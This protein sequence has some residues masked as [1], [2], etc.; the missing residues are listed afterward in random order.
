MLIKKPEV[1]HGNNK[2][3]PY[4]E[5][6]YHKMSLENGKSLVLIPGMYRSAQINYET[7]FLMIY[8]GISN[9][10]K[11]TDVAIAAIKSPQHIV[12]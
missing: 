7:A 11:V 5:G 1:F 8:N 9:N 10:F 2:K 3:R 4:F 12:E 6:W